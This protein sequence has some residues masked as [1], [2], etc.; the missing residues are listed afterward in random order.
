MT[1]VG[2]YQT[3]SEYVAR[4]ILDAVTE[5]G[6]QPKWTYKDGWYEVWVSGADRAGYVHVVAKTIETL[7]NATYVPRSLNDFPAIDAPA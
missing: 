2:A 5:L 6:W 4:A 3:K 1:N 7:V